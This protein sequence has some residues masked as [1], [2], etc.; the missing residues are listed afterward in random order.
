MWTG[1][2]SRLV[3]ENQF[4][5]HH[6]EDDCTGPQSDRTS[7]QAITEAI[8]GREGPSFHIFYAS[9][10]LL[11]LILIMYYFYDCTKPMKLHRKLRIHSFPVLV[12]WARKC[13]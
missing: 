1:E 13:L 6:V 4:P 7:N 8:G 12:A 5:E 10:L 3:R 9:G 2:S 11:F